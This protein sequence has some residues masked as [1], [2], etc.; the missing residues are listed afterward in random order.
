MRRFTTFERFTMRIRVDLAH[1]VGGVV[2]CVRFVPEP[3]QTRALTEWLKAVALPSA[4]G[5]AGV[6]GGFAAEN[7]LEIAN[8]PT[9]HRRSVYSRAEDVEWAVV[10]EGSAA[11]ATAAAARRQLNRKVLAPYGVRCAPVVGTYQL[12]FENER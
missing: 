7:V 3:K 8:A 4:V 10:L 1:G 9:R 2:T 11:A 6:V 12:A 5:Q